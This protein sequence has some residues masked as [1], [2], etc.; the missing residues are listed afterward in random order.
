MFAESPYTDYALDRILRRFKAYATDRWH[1]R[2]RSD[3][4]GEELAEVTFLHEDEAWKMAEG[5]L[6]LPVSEQVPALLSMEY[7]RL[8][9]AL[10]G[11][12]YDIRL[13]GKDEL[14]APNERHYK[15]CAAADLYKGHALPLG[16]VR[17][18]PFEGHY[19]IVDGYHRMAQAGGREISVI[20]ATTAEPLKARVERLDF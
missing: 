7:G 10:A 14:V 6:R 11:A 19:V 15:D 13:I 1:C 5:I 20:V 18:E 4:Y 2:G 16:V 17:H 9:P 12:T 8:L 3:Y